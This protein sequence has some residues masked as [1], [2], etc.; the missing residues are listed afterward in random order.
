M[1]LDRVTPGR[2]VP[3]D[4]NVVIEIPIRPQ[5]LRRGEEEA[6]VLNGERSFSSST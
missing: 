2:A 4:L 5:A 1:S 6:G 3:E